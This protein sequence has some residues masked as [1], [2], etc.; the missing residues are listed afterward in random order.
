MFPRLEV[1]VGG[2]DTDHETCICGHTVSPSGTSKEPDSCWSPL[3]S[4]SG[5]HIFAPDYLVKVTIYV[6]A[7]VC[8]RVFDPN[9]HADISKSRGYF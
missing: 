4:S 3:V 8:T 6:V 2:L 1:E 5:R 7:D 9:V